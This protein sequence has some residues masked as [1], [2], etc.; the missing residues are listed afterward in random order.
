M[1]N[2]ATS[3]SGYI[4]HVCSGPWQQPAAS[5][6][7]H[8]GCLLQ[9]NLEQRC[10]IAI[11]ITAIPMIIGLR[12]SPHKCVLG[13]PSTFPCIS[14]LHPYDCWVLFT[15]ELCLV[16]NQHQPICFQPRTS[17][18]HLRR[19]HP[20]SRSKRNRRQTWTQLRWITSCQV[21]LRIPFIG[22]SQ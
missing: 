1:H 14:M 22:C 16:M 15:T 12:T 10:N 2:I 13:N 20:P 21:Q 18:P 11:F 9:E 7:K 19:T 6:K 3:A 8:G 17:V 4:P 5:G